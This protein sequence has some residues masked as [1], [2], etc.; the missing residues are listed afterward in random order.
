MK[1]SFSPF[2]SFATAIIVVQGL[3][4]GAAR[5]QT[6]I[7]RSGSTIL[8][9]TSPEGRANVTIHTAVFRNSCACSCRVV[10]VEEELNLLKELGLGEIDIVRGL[11]ISVGGKR[12]TVPGA[13]YEEL[14]DPHEA[15]LRFEK[16]NF[17][18][19]VDGADAAYSYFVRLYFRGCPISRWR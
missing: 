8:S 6:K 11:R 7:V 9:A 12:I 5:A 2:L 16:G 19:R 18:L 4:L 13:V 3:F 15:S 17:V 14:F 10:W 1:A